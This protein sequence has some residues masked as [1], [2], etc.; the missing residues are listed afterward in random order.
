[1]SQEDGLKQLAALV[2]QMR[3]TQRYFFQNG[4]KMA[5]DKR[6]ALVKEAK[7]LES[8]VD[9]LVAEILEGATK[10]GLF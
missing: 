2:K 1:M 7:K 9:Q 10:P 8:Q 3:T 4:S 6:A 5:Y